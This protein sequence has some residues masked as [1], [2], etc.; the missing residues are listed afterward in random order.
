[1]SPPGESVKDNLNHLKSPSLYNLGQKPSFHPRFIEPNELNGRKQLLMK[2]N[3]ILS[4][5]LIY[6]YNIYDYVDP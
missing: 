4:R 1:M 3:N 5:N 6:N 2:Q